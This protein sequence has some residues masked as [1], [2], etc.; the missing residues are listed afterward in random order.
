MKNKLD[1][2][3]LVLNSCCCSEYLFPNATN[4]FFSLFTRLQ[5]KS[6]KSL[7][8]RKPKLTPV[9]PNKN[10]RKQLSSIIIISLSDLDLIS[11]T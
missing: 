4:I 5:L 2:W 1:L 6:R 10:Y 3:T 11:T 8:F 7:T 9:L